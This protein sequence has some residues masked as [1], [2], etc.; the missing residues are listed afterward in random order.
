MDGKAIYWAEEGAIVKWGKYG[1]SPFVLASGVISPRRVAADGYFV[2]WTDFDA[3]TVSRVPKDGGEVEILAAGEEKPGEIAVDDDYVYWGSS[4]ANEIRRVEKG[5]GAAGPMEY[6]ANPSGLAIDAAAV[7]W[8]SGGAGGEVARRLKSGGA[9][10]SLF[11][12]PDEIPGSMQVDASG[13]Y[14]YVAVVTEDIWVSQPR[15]IATSG[16]SSEPLADLE[17]TGHGELAIDAEHVYWCPDGVDNRIKRV[18]K[19]GGSTVN[20]A[21]GKYACG[22][23]AVD[24]EHVYWTDTPSGRILRL[25]K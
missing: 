25:A 13:V 1:G 14:V 18:P 2:Y 3:G 19:G 20:L 23:I 16:G 11:A 8:A 22:G 6:A 5:G 4:A 21:S 24:G 7:Y 10:E 12:A 17:G 15:R 9:P